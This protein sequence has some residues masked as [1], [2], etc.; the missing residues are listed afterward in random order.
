L[1]AC[2]PVLIEKIE[3]RIKMG[4]INMKRGIILIVCLIFQSSALSVEFAGGTGEPNNP[5]QIATVEQLISIGADRDLLDKHFILIEDIDLDPNLPGGRVFKDA[6]IAQDGSGDINKH[7]GFSFSGVFDGQ[8][9]TIANLHID[10]I[11]GFSAG[12]FGKLDGLVKNLHLKNVVVSGTPCGTI[13]GVLYPGGAIY[14]CS[15]TGQVSGLWEVG[16]LAGSNWYG[17]LVECEAQ[18][19]VDGIDDVGGMV[20]GGP[21]GYL[22]RCEA[23][24][25]IIG[26]QMGRLGNNVGG[27]V[28]SGGEGHIIECR[29]TGTVRGRGSVGGLIGY[30]GRAIIWKSSAN[31]DV[32]A[33]ESAGGLVGS[34]VWDPVLSLINC[35]ATGPISGLSV[36]GL[37]GEGCH[38]QVINCYSACEF[39]DPGFRS[40][41]GEHFIGGLFGNMKILKRAPITLGC[42]WDTETSGIAISSGSDTLELGTGLTTEQMMDEEVFRN[43]GW[44]FDHV[45]MVSEG[46]YPKLRWELIEDEAVATP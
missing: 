23:Q 26:G 7:E 35:Y 44:D 24:V 36:G 14:G 2:I 1:S 46:E 34:T 19:Q 31:C 18:V 28:G 27:L 11:F 5:Y 15:V 30:T 6:L 13:A 9:H 43:A 3:G 41:A 39:I 29:V 40:R 22:M 4:E 12:L 25:E 33:H 21:G 20:G 17:S 10:A 37:I 42:F 8:G 45:W 38:N 16:G 32:V